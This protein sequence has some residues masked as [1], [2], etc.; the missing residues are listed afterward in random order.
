MA[1][2]DTWDGESVMYRRRV[3]I[4]GG[5]DLEAH[6]NAWSPISGHR[7]ADGVC[8]EDGEP[9]PCSTFSAAPEWTRVLTAHGI[10]PS[11]VQMGIVV[12]PGDA[13]VDLTCTGCGRAARPVRHMGAW[14]SG[15]T[16]CEGDRFC[17][18]CTEAYLSDRTNPPRTGAG[19][20]PTGSRELDYI[21]P[22]SPG[23]LSEE[24]RQT[25]RANRRRG[26][27]R[28]SAV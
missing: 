22:I 4:P 23:R 15:L 19:G 27:G 18:T 9:W 25:V 24:D 16:P 3:E 21:T 1:T 28:R 26:R 12:S 20:T 17:W 7:E 13:E 14:Q 10:Y 2:N 8:A 11:E 5:Y 6:R